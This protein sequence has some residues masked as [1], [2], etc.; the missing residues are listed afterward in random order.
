MITNILKNLIMLY[1]V[2]GIKR[3]LNCFKLSKIIYLLILAL[4]ISSFIYFNYFSNSSELENSLNNT[5]KSF[6]FENSNNE[7]EW[8]KSTKFAPCDKWIIIRSIREPTD[9][10]KAISDSIYGWCLLVVGDLNTPKK[11]HYKDVNYLSLSDQNNLAQKEIYDIIKIIPV[12]SYK[13]KL[14]GY[15]YAISNGARYIYETDDNVLPMEGLFRFRYEKF[16]GLMSAD[17]N[18]D[19]RFLNPLEF[20]FKN[21]P[22]NLSYIVYTDRKIVPAIQQ[23]LIVKDYDLNIPPLVLNN[24]QYS[25]LNSKNTFYSY[26]SFWSLMFP[27]ESDVEN[28]LQ[29]RSFVAI[30]LLREINESVAF[31][32][33]KTVS[34]KYD[35]T[36]FEANVHLLNVLDSWQCKSE[37]FSECFLDCVTN[38]G[39]KKVNI[40]SQQTIQAYIKWI[41]T[42]NLIGYKW[43][44]KKNNNIQISS[45]ENNLV[46]F[47]KLSQVNLNKIEEIQK[48]TVL[49]NC[50]KLVKV[51]K[52]L[53]LSELI[54]ITFAYTLDD[55][56]KILN[57]WNLI[58]LYTIICYDGPTFNSEF[59]RSTRFNTVII[60]NYRSCLSK[61]FS[62]GFRQ[63]SFIIAKYTFDYWNYDFSK[64][65]FDR[66]FYKFELDNNF[67]Q[68]DLYFIR[69]NV[70]NSLRLLKMKKIF[71][72]KSVCSFYENRSKNLLFDG[73]MNSLSSLNFHK[74][75]LA[76][77]YC[78]D[79]QTR[80]I[81]MPDYHDGP[82]VDISST[83]VHLGQNPILANPKYKRSPYAETLRVSKITY[84]MS[85]FMLNYVPF[86]REVHLQTFHENFDYYKNLS[87][88]EQVDAIVCS[89]TV[90]LCEAFMSFN[91]TIILNPAHRLIFLNF[92]KVLF[93]YI[94]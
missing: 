22:K 55:L 23:G 31:V 92:F 38:L 94:P 6:F 35:E 2:L 71:N 47:K 66:I 65:A 75:D 89:F 68:K 44:K 13:R 69:K 91:K 37:E 58:F 60:P 36:N 12:D 25:Q 49:E 88:F 46:Y 56:E 82:R 85:K 39:R 17:K 43:P 7:T 21:D 40:L 77:E 51:D 41:N 67:F 59:L 84:S 74:N 27:I 53:M 73:L 4:F 83:L 33:T 45:E 15:L 87:E 81:W 29:I 18:N 48:D 78:E 90:S 8:I 50:H 76:A 62:M 70:A 19:T 3:L 9:Y 63:Q 64:I 34:K 52:F 72:Y 24:N 11:W 5:E 32:P 57:T 42:L 16:K 80:T 61:A 10:L 79:V 26:N 14:V 54:L 1:K 20:Y 93:L 30:R 28:F 86:E